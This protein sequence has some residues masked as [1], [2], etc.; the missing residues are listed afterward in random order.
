[1]VASFKEATV[2]WAEGEGEKKLPRGRPVMRLAKQYTHTLHW[3][4]PSAEMILR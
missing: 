3:P 2:L 4:N 1:M